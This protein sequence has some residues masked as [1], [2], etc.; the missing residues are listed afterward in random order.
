M[1]ASISFAMLGCLVCLIVIN[2]FVAPSHTP[3]QV[4]YTRPV[5][6]LENQ[7]LGWM[8]IIVFTFTIVIVAWVVAVAIG[9]SFE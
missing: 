6:D 8:A 5:Y 4:P 3:P 7:I 1:T 2:T 9:R